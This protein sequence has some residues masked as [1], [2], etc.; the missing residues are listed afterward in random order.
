M[1][2]F[3]AVRFKCVG[4]SGHASLFLQNTA[5]DKMYRLLEQFLKF[6][7]FEE[8]Q[9]K[10]NPHLTV[11]D[12]TTLNVTTINGGIQQ[13]VIP[14]EV[15]MTVDIRMSVTI[16]PVKFEHDMRD[17]CKQAGTDIEM[18]FIHKLQRIEPTR[19]DQTNV[20]WMAFQNV[21]I[22]DL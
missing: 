2:D 1:C 3:L 17:W 10:Y 13:N 16:D 11:G 8:Q 7:E 20:Y 9:L 12:V 6:R 4:T 14:P 19:L 21:L 22:H 18:E 15:T 5:I